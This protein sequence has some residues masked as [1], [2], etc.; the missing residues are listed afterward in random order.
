[1]KRNGKL[2]AALHALVH[3]AQSRSG[4]MTSEEIARCL[5]TN[6][7]VV[8]R[9]V[10]GLREAGIVTSSKG[11]GGGIALAREPAAISVADVSIALG[12]P[13]LRIEA[14]PET[15]TCLIERSVV[16]RLDLFR[17]EAERLLER[18]L[19]GMTLADIIA[20]VGVAFAEHHRKRTHA[21]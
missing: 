4:V 1:M 11:P 12:E 19:A 8:R 15:P 14:D 18:Q 17:R 7:V 20:D 16:A 2:S 10:A 6:P 9:T 21:S 3:L 13:L 5:D